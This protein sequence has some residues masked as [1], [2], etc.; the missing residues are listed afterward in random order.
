V[1]IID[2]KASHG[3]ITLS[4]SGGLLHARQEL[5]LV[6]RRDRTRELDKLDRQRDAVTQIL[7]RAGLAGVPVTT[8][9]CYPY[10]GPR[11]GTLRTHTNRSSRPPTRSPADFRAPNNQTGPS[12][13]QTEVA[14]ARSASGRLVAVG[15]EA[16]PREQSETCSSSASVMSA[17]ASTDLTRTRDV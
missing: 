13:L 4:D 9:L 10:A 8:V 1:T 16:K 6:N 5:L 2:T 12:H 3:Q 14:T 17:P 7:A 15:D 11:W